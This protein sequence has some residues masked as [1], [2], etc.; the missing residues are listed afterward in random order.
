[1]ARACDP[2]LCEQQG[3]RV[4]HGDLDAEAEAVAEHA[5]ERPGHLDDGRP[6]RLG[7]RPVDQLTQ[8]DRRALLQL[9][10]TVEQAL[11]EDGQDGGDAL[12]TGRGRCEQRGAGRGQPLPSRGLADS[13]MTKMVAYLESWFWLYVLLVID[14]NRLLL[15]EKMTDK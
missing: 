14:S 9:R 11:A 12:R 5:D 13:R 7:A 6:E 3:E 8:T 15:A 4:E 1:M 10:R 2:D